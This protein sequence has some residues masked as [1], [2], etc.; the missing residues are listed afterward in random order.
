MPFSSP[1]L[2]YNV[3]IDEAQLSLVFLSAGLGSLVF[4][5][6]FGRLSDVYGKFKV[7]ALGSSAAAILIYFY[8][9]LNVTPLY[10]V[11]ALFTTLTIAVSSRMSPSSALISAVPEA[12]NRGAFM[13][14]NSSIQQVS[15]GV[16]T[17][18]AGSILIQLED[19]KFTNFHILGYAT[20]LSLFVCVILMS[21][22]NKIV[23]I[24][25]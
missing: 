6:I 16:A 25:I 1:F 24:K 18:I 15:G 13:N 9:N 10:I 19:G 12:R 22:I 8:T 23:K 3:G 4:T 5:P 17:L 11:I 21:V 14:I 2:V 7:F 20:V